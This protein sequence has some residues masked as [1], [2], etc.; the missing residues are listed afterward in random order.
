MFSLLKRWALGTYHGLRRKHVD[1][2]LNEFVFRFNRRF[3]RHI[4]FETILGIASRRGPI[5]YWD[6]VGRRNPRKGVL[7]QRMSPRLRKTASGM[8]ADGS[9]RPGNLAAQ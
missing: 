3:Y 2:Y 9:R 5:G 6:I 8:K 1:T 4:S 7:V